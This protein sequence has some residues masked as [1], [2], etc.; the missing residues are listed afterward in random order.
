[1]SPDRPE[2]VDAARSLVAQRFPDALAA[3]LGGSVVRG[4]A[5]PT[6]DLDVTVLLPGPPAPYRDSTHHEGWPAELFVHT[7]A[8]L[9]HYRGTDQ[10]RRQP[11]IQRLVGESLV[12][13]DPSGRGAELQAAARAEIA[14]GPRPLSPDELASARYAVTDQLDD[15]VGARDDDERLA[16]AV[17]LMAEVG[18]LALTGRRRWTGRGK[19]LLRELRA[20]DSDEGLTLAA[21]LPAAVRAAAGGDV[22]PLVTLVEAVLAP[23]GGR[24]FE[25]HRLGGTSGT[26]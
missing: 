19:G 7:E 22:Q 18:A 26:A 25:G 24:L 5:S 15:L 2:P 11:T 4:D 13:V 10:D 3:W 9:V 8:S 6:S 14:A 1:M 16:V 20:L 21:D 23:H 17:L 12:L